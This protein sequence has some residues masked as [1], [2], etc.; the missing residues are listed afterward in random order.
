MEIIE[1]ELFFEL[2]D[3]VVL[4]VP[5]DEIVEENAIRSVAALYALYYF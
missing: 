5:L 2:F 4:V 3:L 1:I